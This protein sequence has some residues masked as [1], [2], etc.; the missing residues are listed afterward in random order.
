MPRWAEIGIGPTGW[1]G[2]GAGGGGAP[3]AVGGR[4][5]GAKLGG[6]GRGPPRAGGRG[7]GGPRL[8]AGILADEPLTGVRVPPGQHRHPDDRDRP[9]GGEADPAP[10]AG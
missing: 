5:G 10:A 3:C 9:A 1:G 6:G 2:A 8:P 7:G 4:G